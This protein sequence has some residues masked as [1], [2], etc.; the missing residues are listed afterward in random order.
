MRNLILTLCAFFALVNI[1]AQTITKDSSYLKQTII[2][3]I[4]YYQQCR[5]LEYDDG[6]SA[7]SCAARVD[8]TELVRRLFRDAHQAIRPLANAYKRTAIEFEFRRTHN[9]LSALLQTV[10][11]ETYFDKAKE[12]YG[13]GFENLLVKITDRS[14]NPDSAFFAQINSNLRARQVEGT[15]VSNVNKTYTFTG[16]TPGGYSRPVRFFDSDHIRLPNLFGGAVE[17]VKIGMQ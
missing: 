4:T 11:G 10:S 8:S 6:Q 16:F 15:S 17:F 3:G 13:R 5:A 1:Q 14:A 2:D 12:R 9:D 7:I